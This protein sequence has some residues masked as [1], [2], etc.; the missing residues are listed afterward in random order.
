[1]K[2]GAYDYLSKPFAKEDLRAVA[3]R[4]LERRM[5]HREVRYL[6]DE[7][8]RHEGL[9][10][11]VGGS[12]AMRRVYDVIAHVTDMTAS[13]LVTGESGTGKELIARAIHRQGV[14]RDR[15]F[16][17]VNCAALPAE[18][19][20][21]ELFGH[22]RG[23]F[24]GA[25]ARKLG[26]FEV[27]HTGTLFLDEVGA[28]R[29]DLQP[30]LL[31]ALQEREI[32]RVGGTRPIP[33]D[34]RIVA[35]TNVDLRQAVAAGRFREDLYYRLHVVPIVVPPLRERRDDIPALARYFLARYA[36]QFGKTMRDL[37]PGALE[38]LVRYEWPGN[39]RELE[40]II[41]R[42]VALADGPV[43]QLEQI[44]MDVALA[45]G[46]T[47]REEQL[48]LREARQEF[49]RVLILRALDRAEG[50][51]TVAARL[52][53][54]HRNTLCVKLAQLGLRAPDSNGT[55]PATSS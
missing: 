4:A 41:A 55:H 9:G 46:V 43:I 6:R 38:A 17:A 15:P 54:M 21:S 11:L 48:N 31:R 42:S 53:G 39:V 2:R 49:E 23:A 7:L 36:A 3:H 33:V 51:Q 52:L 37:S 34:V 12:P 22:E 26:K 18:L 40:N 8:A 20:E 16:V 24:T 47:M 1:M 28:L 10:Q 19:L 29:L 50:N 32:E 13:I 5:L 44:P 45:P 35:A 25:H 30:K 14:R 27:A